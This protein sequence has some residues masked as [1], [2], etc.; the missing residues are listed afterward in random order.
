MYILI[1]YCNGTSQHGIYLFDMITKQIVVN[2]DVMYASI[3]SID[4]K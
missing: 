1:N 4:H 2:G 3:P